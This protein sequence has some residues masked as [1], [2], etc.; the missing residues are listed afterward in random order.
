M[1]KAVELSTEAAELG[2]IEAL[3]NLGIAYYH[4]DGV[5][6]DK[7]KAVEFYKKA[8]MQGHVESRHNLG[9]YEERRGTTTAQ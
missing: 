5:Q 1:R 6:E 8:A 2:S 9:C 7:A 3:Y 4:G